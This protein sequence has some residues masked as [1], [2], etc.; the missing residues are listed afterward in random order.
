M[1]AV[2]IFHGIDPMRGLR[3]KYLK[4]LSVYKNIMDAY[5]IMMSYASEK[6]SSAR[7]RPNAF[8]RLG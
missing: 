4:S 2:F 1:Q 7:R 8:I 3:D 5:D 6:Q